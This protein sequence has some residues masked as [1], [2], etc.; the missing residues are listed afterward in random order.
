MVQEFR[1]RYALS[2]WTDV[3][4]MAHA[5]HHG[6]PTRLLDWSRNPFVGLWFAV[7]DKQHDAKPGV[8]F[9]LRLPQDASLLCFINGPPKVPAGGDCSCKQPVHVFSSPPRIERTERQRSVFSLA[10]FEGGY[11]LRPLDEIC[12]GQRPHLR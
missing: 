10:S 9:Q 2:D 3:E 5:R 1:A 4:V 12:K 8:V 11:A 6:A 7:S